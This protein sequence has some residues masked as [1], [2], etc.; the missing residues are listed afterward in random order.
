[1]AVKRLPDKLLFPAEVAEIIGVDPQLLADWRHRKV[2][3]PYV[4]LG[5]RTVRY[6]PESV[7]RWLDSRQLA[8]GGDGA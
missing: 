1:M 8:A 7:S 4:K 2:G 3:P 6:N 5:H